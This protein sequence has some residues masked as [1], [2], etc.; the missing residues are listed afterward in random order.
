MK[1]N[2]GIAIFGKN[3]QLRLVPDQFVL[4]VTPNKDSFE[5]KTIFDL[6]PKE[7]GINF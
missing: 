4:W 1:G 5:S 6:S 7:I 2:I 3:W